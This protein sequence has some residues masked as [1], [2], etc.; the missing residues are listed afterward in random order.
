VVLSGHIEPI[1]GIV[2]VGGAY[3]QPYAW[4]ATVRY[5]SPTH[6]QLDGMIRAP[7]PSEWRTVRALCRAA[8]IERVTFLRYRRNGIESHTLLVF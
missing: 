6:I 3:G 8:L 7:R 5:L 2:R 1:A 4:C